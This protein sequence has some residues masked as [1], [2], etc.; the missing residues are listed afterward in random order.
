MPILLSILWR[1][2]ITFKIKKILPKFLLNFHL[3]W[4][5]KSNQVNLFGNFCFLTD[6]LSCKWQELKNKGNPTK[7]H[8]RNQFW[9]RY[10][11]ILLHGSENSFKFYDSWMIF[12]NVQADKNL[13]SGFF[14]FNNANLNLS[15]YIGDENYFWKR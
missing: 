2:L 12:K 5:K 3:I 13:F 8:W 4:V 15:L 9:K 7:I 1:Y 10:A 14:Y 6:L 11:P